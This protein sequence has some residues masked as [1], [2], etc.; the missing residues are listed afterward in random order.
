MEINKILSADILDIIFEGRN[1]DYGAYALRREYNHRLL[2]AVA[3]AFSVILLF[4]VLNALHKKNPKN[5]Y[6][7]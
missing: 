5:I 2:L 3:A 1:K 6:I 4:I 7:E